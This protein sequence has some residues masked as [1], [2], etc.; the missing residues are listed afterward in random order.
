MITNPFPSLLSF[1]ILFL[2][3]VDRC[4]WLFCLPY[5]EKTNILQWSIFLT[6]CPKNNVKSEIPRAILNLSIE[7]KM[8]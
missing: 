4:R 7:K 2:S 5:G 8:E 1:V 3:F 6:S